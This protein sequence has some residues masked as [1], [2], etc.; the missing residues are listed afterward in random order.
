MQANANAKEEM[1]KAAQAKKTAM[2]QLI[3]ELFTQL[4]TNHS[5]TISF[6]ELDRSLHD[7]SLQDYFCV[8]EMEPDEAKDLFC[9]LDVRGEGE[10]SISNFTQG[11]LKIMGAPK[12][13]DICTCMYQS[14]RMLVLLENLAAHIRK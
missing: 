3:G 6:D 14:K 1:L 5:G 8:L 12:N 9:L 10:V 7:E 11:C 4:D 2:I 13:I